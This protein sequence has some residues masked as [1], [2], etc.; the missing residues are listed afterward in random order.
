MFSIDP[1]DQ[2]ERTKEIEASRDRFPEFKN[3]RELTQ[4]FFNSIY[5][6]ASKR[7]AFKMNHKAAS[8]SAMRML[9][10]LECGH[11]ITASYRDEHDINN[12]AISRLLT[13]GDF[14]RRI[15]YTQGG[16][17]ALGS[18]ERIAIIRHP[19]RRV[20]SAF[21]YICL[22]QKRQNR[23]HAEARLEM[24]AMT[25][26][27]WNVHMDSVKGF[28][29]FLDYIEAIAELRPHRRLDG[30]WRQQ[31]ENIRPD[32]FKPTILGFTEFM[33]GFRNTLSERF[34]VRNLPVPAS[35][36]QTGEGDVYTACLQAPGV[37]KRIEHLYRQDFETFGYT[38]KKTIADPLVIE[39]L[40]QR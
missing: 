33:K 8:S 12:D 3:V 32:V 23:A 37:R 28:I 20:L 5:M 9:F 21:L 35:N 17:E 30:H 27:D 7:W 1:L 10:A 24:T 39:K 26:F 19:A 6:P 15:H 13:N 22:A 16:I 36:V 38:Y 18:V 14:F 4:H 34:G 25:G 29:R 2:A 11:H 40:L 31:Y